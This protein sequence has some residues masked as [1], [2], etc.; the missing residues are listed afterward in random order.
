MLVTNVSMP[1]MNGHELAR[2]V[3]K[4]RP[5]IVVLVVSGQDEREF[6]PE[7]HAHAD[8]LLKP[9]EPEA[10]VQKVRELLGDRH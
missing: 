1:G 8:A 10:L 5:E 7:I 9:V 6:P 2:E 3:K 4:L